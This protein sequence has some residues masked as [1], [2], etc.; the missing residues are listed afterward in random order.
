MKTTIFILACALFFLPTL[1]YSAEQK[2]LVSPNGKYRAFVIPLPARPYGN[3]E[4]KIV[5]KAKNGR[6]VFS[7]SYGSED[8]EHGSIVAKA[9]WTPN[10][11][12][13]VYSLVSSGGHQPWHSPTYYLSVHDSRLRSLDDY[14]GAITEPDF[15]LSPPDIIRAVGARLQPGKGF[16]EGSPFE[17]SLSEIVAREKTK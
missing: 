13:F 7:E 3:S 2:T 14:I 11:S 4:S 16:D 5:I 1:T 8:G 15:E 12:F 6:T 17:V 10:S 9:A